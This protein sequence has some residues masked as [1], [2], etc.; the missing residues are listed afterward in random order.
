MALVVR[1]LQ[2]YTFGIWYWHGGY[3]QYS[4]SCMILFYKMFTKMVT[5]WVTINHHTRSNSSTR[6]FTLYLPCYVFLIYIA[7]YLLYFLRKFPVS[8][9]VVLLEFY[10]N[11]DTKCYCCV[12]LYAYSKFLYPY[13]L[14]WWST[15]KSLKMS[16]LR[17]VNKSV[18]SNFFACNIWSGSFWLTKNHLLKTNSKNI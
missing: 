6:S 11:I 18:H 2:S 16:L 13:H 15:F 12:W 1:S 14:V 5:T 9:Y 4:T 17:L 7:S 8:V 10:A 3:T